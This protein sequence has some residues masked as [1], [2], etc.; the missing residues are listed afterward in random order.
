MPRK[1]CIHFGKDDDEKLKHCVDRFSKLLE[2]V[3]PLSFHHS[4]CSR[5]AHTDQRC[6]QCDGNSD[7]EKHRGTLTD[8]CA[9]YKMIT[10]GKDDPDPHPLKGTKDLGPFVCVDT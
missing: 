10:V 8:V 4:K 7:T 6:H 3:S 1:F 2:K 5:T 9:V